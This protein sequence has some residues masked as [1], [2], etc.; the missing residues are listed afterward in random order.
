M[1]KRTGRPS[2]GPRTYVNSPI[3]EPAASAL[4]RYCELTGEAKG[5]TVARIFEAHLD[6]LGLDQLEAGAAQPR[7]DL[8]GEK[9]TA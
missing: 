3:P 1:K 2:K 8:E 7:I 9:R 4:E 5:P 6:D